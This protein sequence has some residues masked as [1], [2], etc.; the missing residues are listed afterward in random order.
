MDALRTR[1]ATAAARSLASDLGLAVDDAVVL[2]N[3]DRLTLR[4][5]PCDVV[6][7]LARAALLPSA[8]F[9]VDLARQLENAGGPVVPLEA[10]VGPRA[11][12]QGDF[13]VSFWTYY[14][15]ASPEP[16]ADAEYADALYRLHAAMREVVDLPAPHFTDR[17]GEAQQLVD[18]PARTPR[19]APADRT[20]LSGA[21]RD[22]RDATTKRGRPEQL[23]HAEPHPGNILRTEKG[24]LFIDLETACRGPV[25]FDIA[26]LPEGASEAY[27]GADA[28]L[29]RQCRVLAI[30]L[31]AA[32]RFDRRDQFPNGDEMG[33]E[34]LSKL[35]AAQRL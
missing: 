29:V 6:A 30:A 18:D 11:Y 12:L 2:Q 8:R 14:A 28:E 3:S 17:I 20:L 1:A 10:R 5:L 21:L 9:E 31:I 23:L 34:F 22:L 35:R 33:K 4:L 24:L 32:W 15:P 27:P 16:A 13:A 7:R 26:S 25:E 19:L